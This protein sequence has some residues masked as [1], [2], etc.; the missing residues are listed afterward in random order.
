MNK[1]CSKQ[2]KITGFRPLGIGTCLLAFMLFLL[3]KLVAIETFCMF[4]CCKNLF[5]K[6]YLPLLLDEERFLR[7]FSFIAGILSIL[8][9]ILRS[10]HLSVVCWKLTAYQLLC[11][12]LGIKRQ[13][14]TD[15]RSVRGDINNKYT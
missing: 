1:D 2:N 12:S 10:E 15:K 8:G 7:I 3:Q 13:K 5:S 6:S 4:L 14:E 9:L 11:S